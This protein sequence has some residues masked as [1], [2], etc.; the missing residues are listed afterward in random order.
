MKKILFLTFLI[1]LSITP[2]YIYADTVIDNGINYLKLNQDSSGKITNGFSSPSQWSAIAFAANDIDTSDIKNPTASLK[3][4]LLT[5][6]PNNGSATDWESRI[7]AIVAI[8]ND[9]TNFGN[10]NYVHNLDSFYNNQQL[11]DICSLNDDIFGLL[12][13]IA[14]GDSS[15]AQIKQDT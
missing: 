11:G 3:D 12:A 10:T 1:L 4:Y 14:S 9:P 5:D 13:L 6:I 7:L 2:S 15:S 8:G